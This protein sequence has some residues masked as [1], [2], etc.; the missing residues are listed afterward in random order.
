VSSLDPVA[1]LLH[2]YREVDA[3]TAALA[4]L[5]AERLVCRS[6]CNQCCLDDITVFEI[7]AEHI[8][9]HHAGLLAAGRPHPAGACAFLDG[10]GACRIYSH[11]PY[12]C[13]SQGLPLRWLDDDEAGQPVEF[14]DICPL[15]ERESEP[16]EALPA[17]DCW[18]L[19]PFESRLARLQIR[20][21]GLPPRRVRLRDLFRRDSDEKKPPNHDAE[22]LRP[23][24]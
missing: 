2:L 8:R 20:F 19:G 16:L 14:R 6:G 13:R 11:R 22:A 21:G 3:Q 17:E 23:P 12:V 9:R 4:L 18:N 24:E 15:N 5:H 7:E 10:R 1:A